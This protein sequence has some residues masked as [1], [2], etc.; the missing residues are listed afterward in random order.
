MG[1][2]RI[3]LLLCALIVSGTV[4][5]NNGDFVRK[6]RFLK[7]IKQGSKIIGSSVQKTFDVVQKGIEAPKHVIEQVP[8]MVEQTSKVI[9]NTMMLPAQVATNII[10]NGANTFIKHTNN[11]RIFLPNIE[12]SIPFVGKFEAKGGSLKSLSSLRTNGNTKIYFSKLSLNIE[13]PFR[14]GDIRLEFEEYSFSSWLVK[15]NGKFTAKVGTNAFLMKL[16]LRASFGCVLNVQKVEVLT[17]KDIQ[18]NFEGSH[19]DTMA[20]AS[21]FIVSYLEGVLK[22][23]VQKALSE[24]ISTFVND[25]NF[26]ICSKFKDAIIN[27]DKL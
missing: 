24:Q 21:N 1:S 16:Q 25:N 14:L 6:K 13:V 7:I 27:S 12:H 4:E 22:D 18:V 8:A 17:L 10:L 2:F 11:D 26:L 15:V 19:A 5:K 9:Q 3:L 23:E 20:A